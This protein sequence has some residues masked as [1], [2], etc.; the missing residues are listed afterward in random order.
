MFKLALPQIM[1]E[2]LKTS[3][4]KWTLGTQE[5]THRASPKKGSMQQSTAQ[6]VNVEWVPCKWV[7]SCQEC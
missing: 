4:R 7:R 1:T 2:V 5:H 6:G 3:K